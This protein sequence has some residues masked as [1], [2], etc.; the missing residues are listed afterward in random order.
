MSPHEFRFSKYNPTPGKLYSDNI[1]SNL[2]KDEYEC[3]DETH[4]DLE[5]EA[6]KKNEEERQEEEEEKKPSRF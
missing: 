2:K 1:K 3:C 5:A 6:K 4:P